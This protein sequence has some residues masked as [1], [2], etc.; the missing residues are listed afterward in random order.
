VN[1]RI[2]FL[3]LLLFAAPLCLGAGATLQN[4][5]VPRP[6]AGKVQ[7][8]GAPKKDGDIDCPKELTPEQRWERMTDDE[9]KVLS[10]RFEALRKLSPEDREALTRRA[11]ELAKQRLDYEARLDPKLRKELGGLPQEERSRILRDHQI[12]QRRRAGE[13]IRASLE[14]GPRHLVEE[15]FERGEGPPRPFHSMRDRLRDE[16]GDKVVKHYGEMGHLTPDEERQLMALSGEELLIQALQIKRKR[17][18]ELVLEVGLPEWINQEKWVELQAEPSVEGFLKACRKAGFDEHFGF[19]FQGFQGAERGHGGVGGPPPGGPRPLGPDGRPRGDRGREGDSR[20]GKP[21]PP[22]LEER[23]IRELGDLLR[24]TLV[25]RLACK[26]LP[27]L[28]RRAKIDAQLRERAAAF[29]K[30][31]VWFSEQD[32]NQVSKR[33]DGDFV[34]FLL[35]F[36]HERRGLGPHPKGEEPKR[37]EPKFDRREPRAGGPPEDGRRQPIARDRLR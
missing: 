25:D 20:K 13:E 27:L 6:A 11:A 29:L 30:G 7:E 37:E 18:E 1:A 35:R 19:D 32:S 26:D 36:V 10:E 12:T 24:P 16:L 4:T 34:E 33:G 5:E 22:T 17:I 15:M 9:R 2:P 28:E 8:K 21:Q 3:S 31:R 23:E 14:E